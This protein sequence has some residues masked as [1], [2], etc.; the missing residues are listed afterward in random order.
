MLHER[1][2]S[3]KKALVDVRLSLAAL[4]AALLGLGPSSSEVG[5]PPLRAS[6]IT[7]RLLDLIEI[8]EGGITSEAL[9]EALKPF[10]ASPKAAVKR[11]I[12]RQHNVG[13]IKRVNGRWVPIN[14]PGDSD[15]IPQ[16]RLG[17][18]S[19]RRTR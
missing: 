17:R 18:T 3:I 16:L 10:T 8:T 19:S 4:E 6:Q 5:I 2:A 11:A 1:H 7:A 15:V 12:N 9:I 14:A 13:R